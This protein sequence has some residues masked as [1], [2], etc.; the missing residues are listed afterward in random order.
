MIYLPPCETLGGVLEYLYEN[1][2]EISRLYYK[3]SILGKFQ[4][5]K[6]FKISKES[7]ILVICPFA[8]G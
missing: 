3:I 8:G 2:Q 1:Y 6:N 4:T 5:D 7:T